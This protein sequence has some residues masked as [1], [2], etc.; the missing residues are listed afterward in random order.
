ML[1][2][3]GFTLIATNKADGTAVAPQELK[4]SVSR[5]GSG[6]GTQVTESKLSVTQSLD[7]SSVSNNKL[8]PYGDTA[9]ISVQ[10]KNEKG[11]GS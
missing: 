1:I 4:V 11:A 6:D 7:T 5:E 2:E 10:L 8:N 3:N 9:V